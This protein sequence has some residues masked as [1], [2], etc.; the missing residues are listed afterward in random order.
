MAFPMEILADVAD[1]AQRES[2]CC[3]FLNITLIEKHDE[4]ALEVCAE[5]PEAVEVIL[6][7][8][9]VAER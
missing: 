3:A 1:L 5:D 6:A 4:L 2:E 7:M 8:T 9:E